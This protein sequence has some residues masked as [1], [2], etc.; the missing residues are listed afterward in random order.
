MELYLI[1]HGQSTANRGDA[2]ILDPPLTELGRQQADRAGQTLKHLGITR[3][4]CSAMRRAVQTAVI[5]GEHLELAPHVFVGIHESG[6][7]W[8]DRGDD[9]GIIQLPG[10]TRSQ[11]HDICPS[12]VLPNDVTDEGWWFPACDSDQ[13]APALDDARILQLVHKNCLEFIAH[14]DQHHVGE[15]ERIGA[16]THGGSGSILLG[17]LLETPL[18]KKSLNRFPH[19]NTGISKIRRTHDD[20]QF[21][22]LNRTRHL[23]GECV[24]NPEANSPLLTW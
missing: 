3:L 1:R 13:Q 15:D 21:L 7:I 19:N 9:G 20:T 17:T 22:Y 18:P 14:L 11:L 2:R 12:V 5:V 10:L 6:G 23:L 8:E 16:I 4:Y 24:S